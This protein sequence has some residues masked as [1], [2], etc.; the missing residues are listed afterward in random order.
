MQC[1]H[2][3]D[4]PLS[5]SMKQTFPWALK[6][7]VSGVMHRVWKRWEG[8]MLCSAWTHSAH[9]AHTSSSDRQL[10][11][12]ER[13][14]ARDTF[15]C[16]HTNA[17]CFHKQVPCSQLQRELTHVA[18]I[19]SN[20]NAECA[21]LK[22]GFQTSTSSP[23]APQGDTGEFYLKPVVA[24]SCRWMLGWSFNRLP[25]CKNDTDRGNQIRVSVFDK[26]QQ[27]KFDDVHRTYAKLFLLYFKGLLVLS[28]AFHCGSQKENHSL[29]LI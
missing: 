13:M 9:T 23:S 11:R 1:V 25:F 12:S 3:V 22:F 21:K 17:H 14:S 27:M 7:R 4:S 6:A 8:L 5:C 19:Y 18:Q 16:R 24:R 10:S 29:L 28:N 2:A 26:I 20:L 15:S